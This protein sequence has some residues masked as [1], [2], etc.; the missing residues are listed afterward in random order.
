MIK[1]SMMRL[2]DLRHIEKTYQRLREIVNKTPVAKSRTLNELKNASIYLKC[3][4]FQR[5]GSF[6]FRGAYNTVS[7]LSS[8]E[9]EKGV[10]AHSSGNHGQAL[11][12]AAGL[13]NIPCIVVMPKNSS[14]V[15][16]NAVANYGAE[17]VLCGI[18]PKDRAKTAQKLMEE[19]GYTLIHPYDNDNMIAGAGTAAYEL[20]KEVGE[21][22]YVFCPVGGGG[23]ISGTSIA[24][25]GLLPRI[26][27]IGVE[28]EKANDAYL[29]FTSGKL[30]P[31]VSPDT[32]AD[33]LRTSLSQRTFEII[34][35]NVHDIVLVSEKE[36]VETMR[37]LWERMKLVVEPSG[38]VS[39]AGLLKEEVDADNL[40]VG[41]ILSG[42]NV[43]LGRFFK[44]YKRQK[45]NK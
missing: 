36:I 35:K 33:G 15:K 6:K 3:E 16:M 13:F 19:N 41:V 40:R 45:K 38:A 26:K 5:T 20:I 1:R 14:K 28:P 4:N 2:M 24:A 42:G 10:I 8:K 21:L 39:L 18:N 34:K 11:A 23:L 31:S 32:I 44:G 7:Q 37:F 25:K 12:L 17:I 29:S 22:D 30:V 9:R 43:D 27:V